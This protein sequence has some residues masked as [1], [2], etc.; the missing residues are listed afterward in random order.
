M[1]ECFK[2]KKVLDLSAFY[3]HPKMGDGHLGKCKE[4]TRN[5]SEQRR[6]I[7]ELDPEWAEKEK[8][9]HRVK[10]ASRYQPKFTPFNQRKKRPKIYDE[11]WPLRNPGKKA[12]HTKVSNAIRDGRLF[13][14][15]CEKCG[16]AAQA[17]H[18]DYSKPLAVRWLCVK[19]H[20][21]HHVE[22]RRL[23]RFTRDQLNQATP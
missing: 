5:D 1:K 2:C 15:P 3:K 6:K 14:L 16:D 21:E 20:N 12:A 17:H 11:P 8:E 22:M 4:C 10:S 7:K 23:E 13:R 19:H 18:D 9:R